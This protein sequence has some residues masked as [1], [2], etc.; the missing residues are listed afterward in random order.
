[1]AET[2]E[3]ASAR[4]LAKFLTEPQGPGYSGRK[5]PLEE[6]IELHIRVMAYDIATE[7]IENTPELREHIRRMTT[8]VVL[9]AMRKDSYLSDI[10][11]NAVAKSLGKLALERTEDEV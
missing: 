3:S 6:R 2:P 9:A 10:V 1:M 7:V 11:I 8:A 5:T 4:Q